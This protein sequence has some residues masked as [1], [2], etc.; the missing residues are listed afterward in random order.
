MTK[1]APDP[2]NK[3]NASVDENLRLLYDHIKLVFIANVQSIARSQKPETLL[4]M[5]QSCK[6]IQP[7]D[8]A[9]RELWEIVQRVRQEVLGGKHA[10]TQK[11]ASSRRR[12][13]KEQ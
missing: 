4:K 3:P 9:N 2:E 6:E 11:A 5:I 7:V 12:R 8:N 1:T 13:T 10:A